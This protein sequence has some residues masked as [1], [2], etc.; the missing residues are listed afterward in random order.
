MQIL[1]FRFDSHGCEIQ[2]GASSST[3]RKSFASA[4]IERRVAENFFIRAVK[5]DAQNVMLDIVIGNAIEI[6]FG[7]L[8]E[9][10]KNENRRKKK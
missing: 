3:R 2:I 6:R 8:S 1:V 5:S 9:N 4:L 7:G 10:G